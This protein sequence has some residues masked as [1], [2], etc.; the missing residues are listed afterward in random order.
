M[1]Y[2]H[3]GYS[4]QID[5]RCETLYLARNDFS[6]INNNY[7]RDYRAIIRT[8]PEPIIA[9]YRPQDSPT[10]S[11][12]NIL[13]A[14]MTNVDHDQRNTD[15]HL[16]AYPQQNVVAPPQQVNLPPVPPPQMNYQN[17]YFVSEQGNLVGLPHRVPLFVPSQQAENMGINNTT[18]VKNPL[19]MHK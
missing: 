15:Q 10:S 9:N 13:A 19:E 4:W 18:N 16:Q 14:T 17:M 6:I 2:S 8:V 3:K 11:E 12:C 1:S 5:R 7:L